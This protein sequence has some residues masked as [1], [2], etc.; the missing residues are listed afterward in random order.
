MQLSSLRETAPVGLSSTPQYFGFWSEK[1]L[2]RKEFVVPVYQRK[3]WR[4]PQSG[5][6]SQFQVRGA[7]KGGS[8]GGAGLD[9]D[10]SLST[11]DEIESLDGELQHYPVM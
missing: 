2:L 6:G 10:G 9:N 8:S 1:P 4:R 3:V 7:G 5:R 11:L